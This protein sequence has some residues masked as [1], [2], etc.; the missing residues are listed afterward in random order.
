[1]LFSDSFTRFAPDRSQVP[2]RLT[3]AL[4]VLVTRKSSVQRHICN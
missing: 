4:S 3:E 1:M 2:I